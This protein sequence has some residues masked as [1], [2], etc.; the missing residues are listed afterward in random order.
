MRRLL[1]SRVAV[2]AEWEREHLLVR[3]AFALRPRNF[4]AAERDTKTASGGLHNTGARVA[5]GHIE[6]ILRLVTALEGRIL[7]AHR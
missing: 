7:L 5:L 4:L 2:R 6:S 3:C 1:V